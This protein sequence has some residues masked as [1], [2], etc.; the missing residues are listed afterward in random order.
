MREKRKPRRSF[1]P[2]QKFAILQDIKLSNL[3]LKDSLDRHGIT[4]PLYYKWKRQ[5]EV[6]VQAS[7]RNSKPIKPADQRQ[8]EVE[9]RRLKEIIL[10]QSLELCELKKILSLPS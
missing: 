6:G 9:N 1:T 7:L 8:L 4:S 2:E 5:L 3:K 10:N